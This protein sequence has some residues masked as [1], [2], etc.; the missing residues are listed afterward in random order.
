M[1]RLRLAVAILAS[2]AVSGA[3][4]AP[5]ALAEAGVVSHYKTGATLTTPYTVFAGPDGK[6]WFVDSGNHL[7]AGVYVGHMPTGGSPVDMVLLPH[8]TLGMA[9]TLGPDGNLWVLQS[10]GGG[11]TPVGW[12]NKVPVGATQT[13]DI[14]AYPYD[15]RS[16]GFGTIVSGPDGRL[17]FGHDK[18]I[19]AITTGGTVTTYSTPALGTI[20]SIVVGPDNRL[21]FTDGARLMRM[22]T[23]GVVDPTIFDLH[24][25][26]IDQIAFGPDG[27]LWYT[28]S[29]P[30]AAIGKM[31]TAGNSVLFDLPS[32]SSLPFGIAP[33]P[34]GRMWFAE[35][36]TDQVGAIP[37]T[38]T[39]GADIKE[40][41]IGP[42]ND[43]VLYLVAGPD[44]R[45]WFNDFNESSLGAITTDA[46]VA[47]TPPPGGGGTTTPPTTAPTPS[48]LQPTAPVLPALPAVPTAVGCTPGK[49]LLTD[50]YPS[51]GRTRLLG[52]APPSAIGR[53]VTLTSTWN[54]KTVATVK[55]APDG[56]FT[57]SAPLPPAGLRATNRARYV[58][59]L[60]ATASAALKFARRLYT[61]GVTASGRTIAV[62]GFATAPLDSPPAPVSIRAASSC[63]T[64]AR[65]PV[66]ATVTPAKSGSFTASI[67]LPADLATA[68][69]VYFRAETKVRRSAKSKKTYPTY[70]LVRGVKVGG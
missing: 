51:G 54:R 5:T 67:T 41:T 24:A 32:P 4:C 45:M 3:T 18:E 40:W 42:S 56:T 55:V 6:M 70:T 64:L 1:R 28:Q 23:S 50:T 37:T 27:N 66:V 7:G 43:G 31:D 20:S 8:T 21:W 44:R 39:S 36:N 2:T 65:G 35:R 30:T 34:D 22:S 59:H 15:G 10:D 13:S 14:T 29:G 52:V 47:T 61:T 12:V 57:A 69:N 60:G 17:W 16:G 48:V 38:A 49:F 25:G 58:A 11:S 9:I 53:T 26:Q 33:G 63:S 68:A 19:D 46:P 62:K